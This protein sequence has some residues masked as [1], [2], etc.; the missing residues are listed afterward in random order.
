MGSDPHE[1]PSLATD[2]HVEATYRLTEALVQAESQMR[3]RVQLLSEVVFETDIDGRFVFLNDAW[4]EATGY[5]PAESLGRCLCEF[6]VDQDKGLCRNLVSGPAWPAGATRPMIEVRRNDGGATWME[7]SIDPI[8][9]GGAVGVLHDVTQRKHHLD[10]LAKLSLVASSTDNLVIITDAHGRTEWVNPAFTARTGFTIEEIAGRKPGDVLQGPDTDPAAVRQLG[11]QLGA[12][13]SVETELLNY[14]RHG[15][16]Y[17][18]RI[19]ITPIRDTHGNVE[20]F[21]SVQTDSTELR[22]TQDDLESAMV[23]AESANEAKTQFLA[24]ISHEM[25]TPLNAILG[26]VDLALD[27]GDHPPE[28][29]EHLSRVETSADILLRLITDI[30]DVSKIEAGQIDVERVPVEIR[31][32][33]QGALGPVAERA[34]EKGLAFAFDYDDTLPAAMTGD[35]VRLRQIVTNLAEN[36]VKF[37]DQGFVRVS[38][39]RLPATGEAGPAL[40]LRVADSG[41]GISSED[42]EHVFERFVQGDGSTT[43]RQGGVGLGL[44]I[45][46]S[47]VRVL[48]GTVAVQSR[49]GAGS[50]FRVTL[51]LVAVREPSAPVAQASAADGAPAAAARVL[52]AEDNDFN[53]AV[54]R[55]YLRKAGHTVERA[56]DGREAVAASGDCDLILMDVEM[57]EMDGLEATRRIRAG[58]QEAGTPPTPV[59]A[60]TAHAVQAYQEQ[61]AE[62]GCTGYL[63]KP[64]RMP[65]LLDAVR[66]A[67]DTAA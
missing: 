44:N 52:V 46:R 40:E 2:L 66:S 39:A 45:V 63:S 25:R 22:R 34:A 26:S 61:C 18:V 30:L 58:E 21:I 13:N 8:A 7:V 14:T 64:V 50:E 4:R 5:E 11:E 20:R 49:P 32:C 42:Q 67:L 27:G 48:G 12:G 38:A 24:T 65:V 23:R 3:R 17:W 57:P 36:A 10:E 55:G 35:P 51:P 6:V 19:H 28:L 43:R 29:H 1:H 62:A 56:H 9:D 60:L 37:T 47:L 16:P 41:I 33:L 31:P 59:I 54:L 15:E 53:F